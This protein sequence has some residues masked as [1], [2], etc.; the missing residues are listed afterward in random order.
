ALGCSQTANR[1]TE[2]YN[3]MIETL[4]PELLILR[5]IPIEE[6]KNCGGEIIAEGIK[7]VREG[8]LYIS[9]G[10]DGQYG[11]I[12]IFT[13]AERKE[14][15]GQINLLSD[16]SI[17]KKNKREEKNPITKTKREEVKEKEQVKET[18]PNEEQL[19][20]ITSKSN[21]NIVIAG[22]GT[23]KTFALVNRI[24]YLVNKAN[25]NPANIIAVTFT[26]KAAE[27]MRSRLYRLIQSEKVDKINI[28]TFHSIC[29]NIICKYS[30]KHF[31]IADEIVSIAIIDE[32]IKKNTLHYKAID[33]LNEISKVK[34]SYPY[35]TFL[36]A[37]DLRGIFDQYQERL[38]LFHAIDFEEIMLKALEISKNNPMLSNKDILVDEFQDIN[39]IQY[40]LL[41]I[42]KGE[43]GTLFVIGDPHQS[44]YGFRGSSNKF[45]E[46]LKVDFKEVGEIIFKYNY[47]ST[48]EIIETAKCII[49]K[50]ESSLYVPIFEPI[51][52]KKGE[53][54]H[55]VNVHNDRD[56]GIFI[57]KK[58]N[59]LIGGIDMVD[60]DRK[61]R[62]K[63][64]EYYSFSEICILFR[65]HRQTEI[66]E[67]CLCKESIPYSV[68]GKEEFLSSKALLPLL[69]FI[70]FIVNP[71]DLLSLLLSLKHIGIPTE[72]VNIYANGEH[73]ISKLTEIIKEKDKREIAYRFAR[74]LNLFISKSPKQ[75]TLSLIKEAITLYGLDENEPLVE[76]FV[77]IIEQSSLYT[78]VNQLSLGREVDIIRYEGRKDTKEGVFLS[79]LHSAKGLE[80][81]AVFIVGVNEGFIPFVKKKNEKVDIEEE[82]RL[83]Y[84][85]ITRA[86]RE[87]FLISNCGQ[88]R[89]R[90]ISYSSSRFI[91]DIDKRHITFEE[92]NPQPEAIQLS[93]F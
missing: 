83:F 36:L 58:I 77:K 53:K 86:S 78:I 70:K 12:E 82:R 18:Q 20:A 76:K 6:I 51:F 60:A 47:R 35:N 14:I 92:Y 59:E 17:S 81:K 38:N 31:N 41:K 1:V 69:A 79:T 23:G 57:A 43:K 10:Y 19:K 66:I 52:K 73:T 87:L 13:E 93:L 85:G 55:I 32:L 74:I 50:A 5:K 49:R 45:F 21:C 30:D 9:A 16:F 84:V 25:K 42:W 65:T 75:E 48:S 26:N 54:I 71:S 28:G 72:V 68:A 22:P 29:F 91:N 4:G 63:R 80:F 90:N 64:E 56:A 88:D 61:N 40:E 7:R 8:K 89:H 33:V 37:E 15:C 34:S 24:V 27:E 44:I 11:S 39:S 3:K 62:S 67:E 2:Y 46:K